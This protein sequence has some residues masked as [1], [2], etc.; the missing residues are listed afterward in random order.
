[1]KSRRPYLVRALYDWIIDN[2]MTPYLLVQADI[3]GVDVPQQFVNEGRIVLNISSD[4]VRD[5]IMDNELVYFSARFSGQP[6]TVSVPV[7][8]ILAIY[9]KENGQG[10]FFD[11]V[12]EDLGEEEATPSKHAKREK[13]DRRPALRLV[14]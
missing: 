4:A 2:Q 13:I 8:A 1:M 5:L 10:M 14:K 3:E 11:G 6:R 9:A 7:R 12:D